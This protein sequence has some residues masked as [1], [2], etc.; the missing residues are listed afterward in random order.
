MAMIQNT[1]LLGEVANKD[2]I[3]HSLF[4]PIRGAGYVPN[5]RE[6]EMGYHKQFSYQTLAI[7]DTSFGGN[8]A[9]NP[10]PGFTEYADQDLPSLLGGVTLDGPSSQTTY[11]GMGRQYAEN[12]EAPRRLIYLQYCIPRFNSLGNFLTGFYDSGHANAANT[13]RVSDSFLYNIGSAVAAITYWTLVPELAIAS[14]LYRTTKAVLADLDNRPMSSFYYAYPAMPL[15]WSTVTNIVNALAVNMK[16]TQG[17]PP[18]ATTRATGQRVKID[19]TVSGDTTAEMMELNR[20]LPD[21]FLQNGSLNIRRAANRCQRKI[22]RHDEIMADIRAKHKTDVEVGEAIRKVIENGEGA[23]VTRDPI[24]EQEY[25]DQYKQSSAGTGSHLLDKLYSDEPPPTGEKAP[26]PGG[27]AQTTNPS[28]E[29]NSD[30]FIDGISKLWNGL[31]KNVA[32]YGDIAK[33][34][35]RDGSAFVCYRTAWDQTVSEGFSSQTAESDL[36]RKMNETSRSARASLFNLSNGNLGDNPFMDTIEGVLGMVGDVL[37]GAADQ[38]GFSGLA[39]LGGKAMANIP[40]FWDSST[41][42]LPSAQYTIPLRSP[43]GNKISILTNILIPLATLIAGATPRSAGRNAYVGPFL[44]KLWDQGRCHIEL[45]MI[46]QMR[47]ER[48]KG[49]LG[50]NIHKQ[51]LGIDVTFTVTNLSKILHMPISTDVSLSDVIGVNLND[52]STNYNAYMAALAALGVNDQ[53]YSHNRWALHRAK[54]KLDLNSYWSVD[55]F[56]SWGTTETTPGSIMS[57]FAKQGYFG[58]I[59]A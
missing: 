23:Y 36:S 13:G 24:E 50:W 20:I 39:M 5:T 55:N 9:I 15:Y 28:A 10:W 4:V 16:L 51:P 37:M 12:I 30:T 45:G 27:T 53:F 46:T 18:G 35:L 29:S 58:G 1:Q 48:G 40:E 56:L 14:L 17:L 44:C 38:V 26:D 21:I 54:A 57:I 2:W 47:I 22:N 34:E 52:E 59:D 8:R 41:T 6:K 3:R 42:D 19:P 25:M 11:M 32:E 43:Y 49:N 33:A 7:G 31:T